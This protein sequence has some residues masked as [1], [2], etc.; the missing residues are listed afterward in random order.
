M[1]YKSAFISHVLVATALMFML[2]QISLSAYGKN[3]QR[4]KTDSVE[5]T[6][7]PRVQPIVLNDW[8]TLDYDTIDLKPSYA[9]V[10]LIFKHQMLTSDTIAQWRNDDERYA[11]NVDRSWLNDDIAEKN[12]VDQLRYNTM[13][14]NPD[15]VYYN[16]NEL[17]EAPKE[18]ISVVDPKNRTLTVA[19][20]DHKNNVGVDA[21]KGE[22]KMHNWLHTFTAS[23]QFSQAYMSDNW[24][25]GANNV[26]NVLSDL[27]WNVQLNQNIHPN[28][29]FSNNVRYKLGINS[30]PND[31][32]RSYNISDDLFQLNTQIGIKAIKKWYYSATL[33]F[34]TQL[35]N[36]YTANTN[37]R[38]AAFLSPGELN[39]GVGI[40]YNNASKDGWRTFNLS[41]SP[42]S[43]NMKLCKSDVNPGPVDFGIRE[44]HHTS[45]DVGSKLEARFNCKFNQS[46]SWS[47]RLYVFSNYEY[48]QGDWEN[49]F[50][51]SV[52][53]NLITQF[54]T[55]L[56]YDKSASR[57]DKWKYWQFKE[58]LSFGLTYR[59]ATN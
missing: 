11:L 57:D 45:H 44:G 28:Y 50:N 36:N 42:I 54:Y 7:L 9:Y 15:I 27:Q 21:K 31:E 53:R 1:I 38:K 58:I 49:T 8:R 40:T 39:V 55:H 12:K 4:H 13:A 47:S 32:L 20:L 16:A 56:R 51:F 2:P 10:P 5:W 18:F 17:P 43:Y 52:T 33:Q 14:H 37:N 3:L 46:I 34:K 6:K 30:A 24:Y 26:L 48:V 35:L 59:F 41:I 19:P 22:I 23:L 29:I 25:Q